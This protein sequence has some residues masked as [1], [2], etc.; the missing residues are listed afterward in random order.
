[1]NQ[2]ALIRPEWT[3]ATIALMVLGFVVFW[4]LG[5]AMLAYILFGDRLRGFK[6]DVNQAADGMFSGFRRNGRRYRQQFNSE[7]VAFDDWR[8]AEL[9][10][11][12]Q[13][14]RRLDETRADFDNYVRELRRAKDQE[15]F[16]RFMRDRTAA[17]RTD[18][19]SGQ[20]FRTS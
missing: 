7:N 20:E 5:L 8:Q 1:M 10:R 18:Q 17:R 14:R 19:G 16:D 2:S 13:E 9:D 4:P 15:E 3:P 12:D 11:L 6:R